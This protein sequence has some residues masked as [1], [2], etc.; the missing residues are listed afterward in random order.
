IVRVL[1]PRG[2]LVLMWNRPSGGLSS[3]EWP[4]GVRDALDRIVDPSPPE[5]R[6]RSFAWRD[7]L[8]G[9]PFEELRFEVIPNGGVLDRERLIARI[10]SWSQ[11]ASLPD[12]ERE[13][14]LAEIA[15]YLTEPVYPVT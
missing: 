8:A 15:G 12:E 6:Y 13:A 10:G 4:Q 3:A 1:E 7:A 11:V 5:R 2:G 9:S 14:F